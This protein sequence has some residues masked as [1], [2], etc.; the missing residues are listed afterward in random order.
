MHPDYFIAFLYIKVRCHLNLLRPFP[1]L[2]CLS[3]PFVLVAVRPFSF[4]SYSF[5]SFPL[6]LHLISTSTSPM[7]SNH[8]ACHD[9]L[10]NPLFSALQ[11]VDD[12][13]V[14]L[15]LGDFQSCIFPRTL[16]IYAMG[17]MGVSIIQFWLRERSFEGTGA[18]AVRQS[19][20]A[21]PEIKTHCMLDATRS[22]VSRD[23]LAALWPAFAV[24]MR[25]NGPSFG[26]FCHHFAS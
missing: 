17:C 9:R 18:F 12:F 24:S 22:K 6:Y 20:N 7:T 8:V 4:F 19:W 1:L 26:R 15:K 16:R 25:R 11:Y 13:R 14:A 21:I 2:C 10:N 5:L 23:A 3:P